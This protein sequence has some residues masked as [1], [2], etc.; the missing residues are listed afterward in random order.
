ML[1]K[2]LRKYQKVIALDRCLLDIGNF[3]TYSQIC[4]KQT[5]MRKPKTG[6]LRKWLLNTGIF[7]FY[8]FN[9]SEI[10]AFKGRELLNTGGAP[11]GQV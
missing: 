2:H 5:P 3:Y 8:V 4:V 9:R 7:Q 1:S 11:L 10:V 6:C